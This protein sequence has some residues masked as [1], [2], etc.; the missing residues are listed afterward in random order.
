MAFS[1]QTFYL[2]SAF[3]VIPGA[4]SYIVNVCLLFFAVRMA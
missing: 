3:S 2:L 4:G 1:L